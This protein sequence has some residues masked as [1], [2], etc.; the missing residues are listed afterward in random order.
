M[1]YREGEVGQYK[2][3]AHDMGD[4]N[5]HKNAF[6]LTR[7]PTFS[8]VQTDYRIE[9]SN[10]EFRVDEL[11]DNHYARNPSRRLII[12]T[13]VLLPVRRCHRGWSNKS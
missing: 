12:P 1:I 11:R 5:R 4:G 9:S 3:G 13:L 6:C 7:L 10:S 8:K 2:G